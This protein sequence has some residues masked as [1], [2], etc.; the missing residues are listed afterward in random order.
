MKDEELVFHCNLLI[1]YIPTPVHL[2]R[3]TQIV[4]AEGIFY[5][6]FHNLMFVLE[7]GGEGK[8]PELQPAAILNLTTTGGGKEALAS[9][10]QC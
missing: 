4:A 9:L 5:I 2:I 1:F 10:L 3:N 7:R 8:L 6:Y